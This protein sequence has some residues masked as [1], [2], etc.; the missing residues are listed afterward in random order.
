MQVPVVGHGQPLQQDQQRDQIADDPPGLASG[1]FGDVGVLLLR[2]ERGTRRVG[3]RNADEAELGRGPQ[4]EVFGEAAE[5]N[6]DQ[7]CGSAEFDEEVP[8]GDGVHG[9]LRDAGAAFRIGKTQQR[10]H[11]LAVEGQCAAGNGPRSKRTDVQSSKGVRQTAGVTVEHLDVGQAMVGEEDRL[12]PLQ[13][14]VTGDDDLRVPLAQFD[15]R[16]LKPAQ[17]AQEGFD[18]IP[19][20]ESDIQGDLIIPG[21]CRV[22][23]GGGRHTSRQCRLDVHVDILQFLFPL[24]APRLDL[25]ADAFEPSDDVLALLRREDPDLLQH[26]RMGH[27]ADEVVGP[28]SPVEGDRLGELGDFLARA[29][30]EAAGTGDDGGGGRTRFLHCQTLG[31]S[32]ARVVAKSR[33]KN[34]RMIQE[35]APSFKRTCGP[36]TGALNVL[37]IRVSEAWVPLLRDPVATRRNSNT[38]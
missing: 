3:I 30:G 25:H 6:G 14:R 13:V 17:F 21:S 1:E 18:L 10:G 27:R 7:R 23:L 5:V 20:P 11:Q 19:Q 33:G 38:A 37:W 35:G 32:F 9:I 26:G 31:R 36:T 29:I 34:S 24:E 15:Q 8:V 16:A 28:E 2:H 22:Q 12:G 4:D